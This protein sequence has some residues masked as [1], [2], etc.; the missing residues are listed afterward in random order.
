MNNKLHGSRAAVF[1]TEQTVADYLR[2]NPDFFE[3]HIYLLH[4]LKIPH[5]TG[6]AASLIER[7]VA[8]LR[9]E[10]RRL[11]RKLKEI[12]EVVRENDQLNIRMQQLTLKLMEATSLDKLLNALQKGL[13]EDFQ[14]DF[15]NVRLIPARQ[16]HALPKQS[17]VVSNEDPGLAAFTHFF[18]AGQPLCG[19]LRVDQLTYL[20]DDAGYEVSS[21][22]L[23]PFSNRDLRGMIAIGSKER[24]RFQPGIGTLFLTHLG[25]LVSRS[26][27]PLF[28]REAQAPK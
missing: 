6:A 23:V 7:Q 13:R 1:A 9:E 16:Y 22:A 12:L 5:A 2:Q 20:F 24:D 4:S 11:T 27:W 17:A 10:N 28:E 25:E 18:A 14:A 15:V 21:T 26:I 3:R 19:R 8:V